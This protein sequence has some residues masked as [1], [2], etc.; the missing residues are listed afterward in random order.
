MSNS[1]ETQYTAAYQASLSCTVSWRWLKFMSIKSVM[2]SNQLILCYTSV[3]SGWCIKAGILGRISTETACSC[4]MP[5]VPRWELSLS[6]CGV[7]RKT[8]RVSESKGVGMKAVREEMISNS[9]WNWKYYWGLVSVRWAFAAVFQ[10]D[11]SKLVTVF[12]SGAW[13][14]SW[15]L[16][17][18]SGGT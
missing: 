7:C 4:L 2:L 6:G 5:V 14:V 16:G 17:S 3:K 8:L 15:G 12:L 9:S 1:F 18:D 10:N 13:R 11:D